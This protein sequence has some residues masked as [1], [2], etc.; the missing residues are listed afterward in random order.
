[1]SIQCR[2]QPEAIDGYGAFVICRHAFSPKLRGH[3]LYSM[4][5]FDKDKALT[6]LGV[7]KRAQSW[8]GNLNYS[9][10]PKP[11]IGAELIWGQ[12]ML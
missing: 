7:T 6:G 2:R 11:D 9:S 12:R 1:M 3:V 10:F 8:H 5:Y 4:A